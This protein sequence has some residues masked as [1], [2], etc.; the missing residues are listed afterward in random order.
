M[1]EGNKPDPDTTTGIAFLMREIYGEDDQVYKRGK[2][3]FEEYLTQLAEDAER[4]YHIWQGRQE[5]NDIYHLTHLFGESFVKAGYDL[6][7]PRVN[8]IVVAICET[9]RDDGGWRVFWAEGSDPSYSVYALE[10][11]TQLEAFSKEE[12]GARLLPFCN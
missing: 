12:L 4:G 7:D 3:R 8:K 9:Q 11:L 5:K 6:H 10:L 2:E 1:Y